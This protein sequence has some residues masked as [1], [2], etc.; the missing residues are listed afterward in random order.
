M[1]KWGFSFFLVFSS[2]LV[3]AQT[4][5][6]PVYACTLPGTQ[7]LTSGMKSTNYQMGVIRSCTVTVYLTGTITV[8]TTSPQSPFTANI[9]GSIPPIYAA[10]NQ[11]YD[12]V[13][14][15]GI[16]PNTYAAPVTL[17][18]LYPG[19]NFSGGFPSGCGFSTSLGITCGGTGSS[20]AGGALTNLGG[21]PAFTL[22]T[23]G[24]SGPATYSGNVINIP[25]YSGGSGSGTVTDDAGTSTPNLAA[26]STSTPHKITYGTL[27]VAGGGTGATTA[28]AAL[29]SLNAL[30]VFNPQHYGA[31][32]DGST[33]DTAAINSAITAACAA[34]GRV[35]LPAG[36]G[37]FNPN[38]AHLNLCSGLLIEGQGVGVSILRVKA[39]AGN[40]ATI[41]GLPSTVYSYTTFRNFTLD[42]NTTNNQPT[43]LA[44]ARQAV[45]STSGGTSM[46]WDHVEFRDVSAINVIYTGTPYTTVRDCSIS[47]NLTGTLAHDFS[48]LYI[49]GDHAVI[50]GNYFLGGV[51]VHG[52]FIG[53]NSTSGAV[54]AIETHGG[55]QTITGNVID[56]YE[57]GMNITGVD[58]DD[59]ET[60]TITGNSLDNIGYQGILFWSFSYSTHTT[61]YGLAGLTVTGNS[62]RLKNSLW[63]KAKGSAYAGITFNSPVL[64]GDVTALPIKTVNIT[65]NNVEFDPE[66]SGDP[67]D[68]YPY[69][70]GIGFYDYT[71]LF[72]VQTVKIEGNTIKNSPGTCVSWI[73][74]GDNISIANNQCV[75]PGT[76][77]NSGF[78]GPYKAG[79]F[80]NPSVVIPNLTVSGNVIT[81]NSATTQMAYGIISYNSLNTPFLGNVVNV[82]GTTTAA[83]QNAYY[84]SSNIQAPLIQG[85]VNVPAGKDIP[86]QTVSYGS[87]INS[88][89]AGHWYWA[90]QGGTAWV[91]PAVTL[92]TGV[93]NASSEN[94]TGQ[95]NTGSMVSSD[96]RSGFN[97]TL[98]NLYLYSEA[99]GT[100][101][102]YTL[103]ATLTPNASPNP[104][105]GMSANLLTEDTSVTT[106][107]KLYQIV[108]LAGGVYEVSAYAKTNGRNILIQAGTGSSPF[109]A[110]D[111]TAGTV[112][113]QGLGGTG[114]ISSLG[115]GVY[116]ISVLTNTLPSGS[117]PIYYYLVN[118]ACTTNVYTG[119]GTSGVYL[120]GM[121]LNSGSTL[122]AYQ[123]TTSVAFAATTQNTFAPHVSAGDFSVGGNPAVTSVQPAL[124]LLKGTYV[125]GDVCTYAAPGTLL[126]CN[127][128][129]PTGTV[130]DGTGSTTPGQ[131]AVSTSTAHT[132]GYTTAP[133]SFPGFG[134][135]SGTAAQGNDSRIVGAAQCT[136]GTANGNCQTNQMTTL[137]D[138]QYGGASGAV[139]RLA[140][141]TGAASTIYLLSNT[142]TSGSAAQAEAWLQATSANTASTVVMRD[143]SNNI[144]ATTFTGALSGNATTAT[145]ATTATNLAGGAVGSIPYQTAAGATTFLAGN[146][147][148]TKCFVQETGTGSAAQA[149]T[150][151]AIVSADLPAATSS[152][153]GAVIQIANTTF[154]V[155][156][157]TTIANGACSPAAASSATQVAMTGVTTGM[158]FNVTATTDTANVTGWG[159]P[160]AG[161][162]YITDYPTAG[163]F[164]YHVC[165]NSGAS[166]TTGG[167]VTFNVSAR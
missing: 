17:T 86:A 154:T 62:V 37:I 161:V 100:V 93:L 87:F 55:N 108:T 15:G 46:L 24:T 143:S 29:V 105:T 57:V 49:A 164:N 112:C 104:F 88:I 58:L 28:P 83:F 126:N 44:L 115:G 132:I 76:A 13:L 26:M 98:E 89:Q 156:S 41:F 2:L 73:A 99:L 16:A 50:E 27:P 38:T 140:G 60:V 34:G 158:T 122:Y 5:V 82:T 18:G 53:G 31:A 139:T 123:K 92:N 145:S 8:A 35:L 4:A 43:S 130:S 111:L 66:T 75:N 59:S 1:L 120:S 116:R 9:N 48:A 20:T 113:A 138:M 128:T 23:T 74:N 97:S 19:S 42:Y 10:V 148:A 72:N 11:G 157:S 85:T 152:A 78:P 151:S 102:W 107:H 118:S 119:D 147:S 47:L 124:S 14:S 155:S 96:G 146:T 33:D 3:Q 22:T 21:A 159:A 165:N 142:T 149:P 136:A 121:Q 137:G 12:V 163:Y 90:S 166:I 134:T 110:F 80:I 135:T 65:G 160:A 94:V 129:I 69:D 68:N 25:Q 106:D 51:E 56:G 63:A 133:T 125:D 167:S 79:I 101:P 54:T 153:A 36:V 71:G 127:T 32:W 84:F 67:L 64:S 144:N 109:A 45:A 30:P 141:P 81:D 91:D 103:H 61:G 7:A 70:I 6:L 40:Y 39:G 162:L 52:V 95:I 114:A 131:M 150:C 117:T 77:G